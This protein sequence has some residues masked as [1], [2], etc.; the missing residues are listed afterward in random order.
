[1]TAN[2]SALSPRLP[3][4]VPS[5]DGLRAISASAVIVAHLVGT[6]NF[7]SG[8]HQLDHLGNYGV[9]CFF[10]ISG[11]LITTLLLKELDV[12]GSISLSAFYLRRCLRIFP[13]SYAYVGL[14]SLAAAGGLITLYPGDLLHAWTYTMNYQNIP[15]AIR[16]ARANGWYLNHL[17]SL[18]VEEQFYLLWPAAIVLLTARRALKLAGGVII[19]APFIRMLMWYM[20]SSS[21][22]DVVTTA[23]S[24]QF[25]A[26]SDALA[27]GCL[28]AGA[29]NWLGERTR[30]QAFLRSPYFMI[31]LVVGGVLP[32]LVFLKSPILFFVGSQTVLNITM[33][34]CL[35]RCVRYPSGLVGAFLNASPVVGI[36]VLSYSLYLWQELFLN[37]FRRDSVL[38]AFPVNLLMVILAALLSYHAVERPFLRLKARLER[39]RSA[40]AGATSSHAAVPA[41]PL[42]EDRQATIS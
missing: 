5:L 17:W 11:F 37:P 38:F 31:V 41:T 4:R 32:T 39:R 10:I 21:P 35:E 3:R 22:E 24:R 26:V 42:T 25:E 23:L 12:A 20:M 7:P 13:A 40:A 33:A 15:V 36:G 9:R 2:A 28:L 27:T 18:S 30:Y 16:H 19:A 6:K 1:M 29:Y 34:L 8:L 14:I